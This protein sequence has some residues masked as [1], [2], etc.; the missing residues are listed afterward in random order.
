VAIG[1][2]DASSR[3]AALL[4]SALRGKLGEAVVVSKSRAAARD[5]LFLREKGNHEAI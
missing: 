2:V 1:C 4:R 5:R 3:F